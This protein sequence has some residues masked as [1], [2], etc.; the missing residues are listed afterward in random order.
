MNQIA[1][2]L[3]YS[4]LMLCYSNRRDTVLRER[5]LGAN[6]ETDRD[7]FG[8]RV[9]GSTGVF[10]PK[11]NFFPGRETRGDSKNFPTTNVHTVNENHRR[12]NGPIIAHHD[13][14]N[15]IWKTHQ[16]REMFLS[17]RMGVYM[18]DVLRVLGVCIRIPSN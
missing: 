12:D 10:F 16:G 3:C 17:K 15:G 5:D 2:I 9:W 14:I 8:D 7:L 18:F 6:A 4:K 11:G 1:G 13:R